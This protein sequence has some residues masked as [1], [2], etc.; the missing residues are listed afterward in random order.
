M[1]RTTTFLFEA[2]FVDG[3]V[4]RRLPLEY[5]CGI[6]LPRLESVLWYAC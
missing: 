6:N 3:T 5:W 1:I 4:P 2:A